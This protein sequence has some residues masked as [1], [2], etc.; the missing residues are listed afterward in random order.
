MR[1]C[2][3]VLVA[4]LLVPALRAQTTTG[5]IT[6]V[7][8]DTSKAVL[9]AADIVAIHNETGEQ[10]RTKTNALGY[11]A[12]PLLAPGS[13]L[14]EAQKQGFR[15]AAQTGVRVSVDEVARVDITLDLGAVTESVEV[16][17]S[18][19][20]VESQSAAIGT[21][22]EGKKIENLPLNSRNSF[23]LALLV[24]GVVPGKGFGDLF[25][26]AAGFRINGGRANTNEI[27]L[28][29]ITN[30]APGA[31]PIAVVA[32]LPS[33]DALQEFK[34]LTNSFSAEYGRSGGG[35]VNMILRSGTNALHGTLFEFLRNSKLDSND[36]FANRSGRALP[37]FQRNQFGF[38]VGG[39][40]L[41]NK[42]FFFVNYE[43]LR[44]LSAA[45][46][47]LTVPTLLERSGDFSQSRQLV[48]GACVPVML[49][50][51]TTT[52]RNA[53]G[54]GFIR[55]AFP[56]NQ[57][58]V[59]RLDPVGAKLASLYPLPNTPGQA[60]TNTNNFFA[61]R[62]DPVDS[63]QVNG[64]FD[65]NASDRDKFFAGLNWRSYFHKPPNQFGT[66]ADSTGP[67]GGDSIPG[68]GARLDYTRV[69]TPSFLLNFR[70]GITR[71]ERT[72]APYPD[73]FNLTQLGF[74]ASFA[75]Q[76][77]QPASVPSTAVAGYAQLG[78]NGEADYTFQSGT[79]YSF[80]ANATW[81]HGRH[82]VKFG[83][84]TRLNQSFENSGFSTSGS[85]TFD[86]S[87]TQGPDPNAPAVNRGNGVASLL[88]G[89]GT[90]FAQIT[91]A[92]LTSN[93]YSGVY[94]QDDLRVSSRLALNIGLR[95]DVE[96]GRRERYN[97]LSYFDFNAPSPLA[98]PAGL[99]NLRGGLR[100][101]NDKMPRQF[102]TD[103]N[104]FGPRV[105]FAYTLTPATVVRAGYGIFYLPF[106]GAAVG[107]AAGDNGFLSNT[108]WLSSLDGLTPLNY[109]SNPFPTGLSP[110]TG[111]SQG[112]SS[113]VGQNLG[114][115]RDGAI[116]R[117]SRVG[118][119][120]EWN[121][122][123]QRTLPGS[124]IAEVAYTGNKGTKLLDNG[125]QL[126]QLTP[127][128]LALGSQLQTLVP[129][130]FYGIIQSGA[131][132]QQTVTR[133]QLLR[134]YP[135]FLNVLDY[136]P[137]AASS[138]YHAVQ[139]RLQKQFGNGASF[140]IA[141][142]GGK[143]IDDS[144]GTSIGGG[145]PAPAHENTYDR[146]NDRSVSS[147]DVSQRFVS[148]FVYQLPFGRGQRF[149]KS[150]PGWANQ[151]FGNWQV[152]GIVTL[153]TG[154]PL[155]LT[156]P[157]NSGAFSDTQRPN[158]I[159]DPNLPSGR[160]TQDTLAQWFD[161]SK[162][163]QPAAFTFGNTGR[164]LPNVRGDGPAN[165]DFSLF[166]QFPFLESRRVEFRA[167][168]FN[169][170]NTPQFD[171]PGQAFGGGSFGVVSAQANSPRQVQL[172]L[173]VVF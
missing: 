103:W 32:I 27:L 84:D 26:T 119:A 13:Y 18:G 91:P 67:L 160:S 95:Y 114:S 59:N 133:G 121:L 16:K 44:Q 15:P 106:V 130:P 73:N 134:P 61:T 47:N 38:T 141:Y 3:L 89:T 88:L 65:W 24:P 94:L 131:L 145:G 169:L 81:V 69:Q 57:I 172:A 105:G 10:R 5:Q 20:E 85:F 115:T 75:Q 50:D 150:L 55:D 116:D 147:Q 102:D 127:N 2:H 132:A 93:N 148:S 149:G 35:I 166:K 164:T 137:A 29:G 19:A 56:G 68:R 62:K 146:R 142:T 70:F 40:I 17:A 80:N 122:N 124:I 129:N 54:N 6:G 53:A 144:A 163:S 71:L 25:N 1:H 23:A 111:S 37:S 109:L 99:P 136:R 153:S 21:V 51:P 9:P 74:P 139:V 86:R 28:D 162:F 118:Y 45:T 170:T 78:R 63:N 159:G 72:I 152:N 96:L 98:G 101:V 161:T 126:N 154:I 79:T 165:I 158:V 58:P 125:W 52:R 157:N 156:A 173:K 108:P 39:P 77:L 123:V 11:Y 82:N 112:L 87:F 4:L 138:S 117:G 22:V 14:V 140:L 110:S 113:V 155:A 171:L 31:N 60:C 30:V 7:V 128:Q 100:F 92:L 107:S 143:L 167:E 36:F 8:Q 41:K 48:G 46:V 43:G 64:K 104:N 49:F 34:I 168:A 90:G 76:I 12:F 33:P 135:Q 97:Q 66:I 151:T 42:L 83:I 120:Q